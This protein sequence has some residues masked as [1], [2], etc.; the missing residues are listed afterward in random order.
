M[1][2]VKN[3]SKSG[4]PKISRRGGPK[5]SRRGS[6]VSR[7]GGP[8]VSGLSS[9]R[10]S[11]NMR[12]DG[13]FPINFAKSKTLH[14]FNH[15]RGS[16]ATLRKAT[17]SIQNATQR[18][19]NESNMAEALYYNNQFD[20]VKPL[21][22]NSDSNHSSDSNDSNHYSNINLDKALRELRKKK[23]STVKPTI[24]DAKL[25]YNNTTGS[26]IPPD[27]NKVID[28]TCGKKN[29]FK[30]AF[31]RECEWN[32]RFPLVN[33]NTKIVKW[34]GK[35]NTKKKKSS[36]K[37]S[38]AFI[39]KNKTKPNCDKLELDGRCQWNKKKQKCHLF[40]NG[41]SK[42]SSN[43]EYTLPNT[44]VTPLISN[45]NNHTINRFYGTQQESAIQSMKNLNRGVP[46]TAW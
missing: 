42:K 3:I 18:I 45:K 40:S 37:K 23:Q 25:I 43:N 19:K 10:P 6:K 24:I 32:S 31:S 4:K 5:V 21:I 15:P 36:K 7:M 16:R 39:C 26:W 30:C 22:N 20:S 13:R 11:T 29:R 1:H 12:P 41:F 27:S 17:R 38:P 33:P 2:F 28:I 9:I 35:C 14:P 8:N 44:L 34:I 46:M